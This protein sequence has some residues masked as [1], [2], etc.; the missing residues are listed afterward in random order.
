MA[1]SVP[2][3]WSYGLDPA[4]IN[5]A[6]IN[7]GGAHLADDLG[8]DSIDAV[9]LVEHVRRATGR[10]NSAQD[11]ESMRTVSDPARAIEPLVGA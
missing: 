10:K 1:S 9:D 5:P 6:R 2:R 3:W 7:P 8:V 11:F 4:R